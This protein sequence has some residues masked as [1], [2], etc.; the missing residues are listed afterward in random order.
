ML[1]AHELCVWS[2][3][4]PHV[5]RLRGYA[6]E[7]LKVMIGQ[8]KPGWQNR[9]QVH[10]VCVGVSQTQEDRIWLLKPGLEKRCLWCQHVMLSMLCHAGCML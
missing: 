4:C 9:C 1:C 3:L 6:V 8:Q 7:C 10:P 5:P 2:V